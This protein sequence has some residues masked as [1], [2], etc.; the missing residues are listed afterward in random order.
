MDSRSGLPLRN[1]GS[2]APE[3][4]RVLYSVE[5]QITSSAKSNNPGHITPEFINITNSFLLNSNSRSSVRAQVMR[6]YHRRR[7]QKRSGQRSTSP[8]SSSIP[9]SLSAKDQTHR[10]RFDGHSRRH[11]WNRRANRTRKLAPRTERNV[12]YDETKNEGLLKRKLVDDIHISFFKSSSAVDGPGLPLGDKPG[13]TIHEI[14]FRTV[15]Q[16]LSSIKVSLEVSSLYHSVAPGVLEPFSAVSLLITP[17]TQL[18]LHHYCKL[19]LYHIMSYFIY[20]NIN[21]HS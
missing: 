18:L 21:M 14:Q 7:I 13:Q 12:Q 11:S 3:G 4:E 1:R 9:I 17:R 19:T 20:V 10:F 6:D 8:T 16:L 15:E 2:I 5:Q